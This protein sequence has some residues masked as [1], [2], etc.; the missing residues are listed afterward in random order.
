MEEEPIVVAAARACVAAAVGRS[1]A[2]GS[3]GVA[4]DVVLKDRGEEAEVD[5]LA[6]TVLHGAGDGVAQLRVSVQR[7]RT[8]GGWR[9]YGRSS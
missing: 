5:D 8:A 3:T 6:V 4:E 7:S 2:G 1:V 9:R